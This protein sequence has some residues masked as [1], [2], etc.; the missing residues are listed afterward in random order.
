M[1]LTAEF[2]YARFVKKSLQQLVIWGRQEWGYIHTIEMTRANGRKLTIFFMY[3]VHG[4]PV[5][6]TTIQF[7]SSTKNFFF[8][9]RNST[10]N[11]FLQ[12]HMGMFRKIMLEE[13]LNGSLM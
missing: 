10:V 7:P 12:K 8:T 13:L 5:L 4:L 11:Y 2:L 9:L 6:G 1:E 3:V